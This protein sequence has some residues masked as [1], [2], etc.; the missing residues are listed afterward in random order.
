MK[1][2]KSLVYVVLIIIIGILAFIIFK[3]VNKNDGKNQKE[4]AFS[5]TKYVESK[6]VNLLNTMNNI[7]TRN[8][9]ISVSKISGESKNLTSGGSSSGSNSEGGSSSSENGG[10]GRKFRFGK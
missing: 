4:K 5:E 9:E 6:L 8:Y 7:E 1:K 2:F 3:N 10:N